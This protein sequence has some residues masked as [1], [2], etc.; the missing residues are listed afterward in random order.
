M[1]LLKE[2]S[3]QLLEYRSVQLLK[4]RSVLD[5]VAEVNLGAVAEVKL[6]GIMQTCPTYENTI[7]K[8]ATIMTINNR[9]KELGPSFLFF[10]NDP[11]GLD[12]VGLSTVSK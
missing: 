6:S 9:K 3:V 4:Y 8:T 7:L 12:C 11:F 5:T 1:Q 10:S 2:R